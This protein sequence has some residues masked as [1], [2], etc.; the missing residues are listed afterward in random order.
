MPYLDKSTR[1]AAIRRKRLLRRVMG[2]CVDCGNPAKTR[3]CH[4]CSQ[5][6]EARRSF[7]RL[8]GKPNKH[9]D[10]LHHQFAVTRGD[11]RQGGLR[12]KVLEWMVSLKQV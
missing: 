3:R 8:A 12:A 11:R 1:N 2:L 10:F 9:T 5:K 7:A 6:N 4:L